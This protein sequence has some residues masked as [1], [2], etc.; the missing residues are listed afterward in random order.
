ML[1]TIWRKS[2]RPVCSGC[3]GTPLLYSKH[4]AASL[5]HEKWLWIRPEITMKCCIWIPRYVYRPFDALWPEAWNNFVY[6]FW[7]L[8]EI[9]TT[10]IEKGSQFTEMQYLNALQWSCKNKGITDSNTLTTYQ[11]KLTDILGTKPSLGITVW[12][13]S[14]WWCIY[15]Y[16]QQTYYI[17]TYCYLKHE[18]IFI[19]TNYYYENKPHFHFVKVKLM[20]LIQ[21]KF[22]IQ[23][24]KF[25]YFICILL[26]CVFVI[27]N[28]RQ[29]PQLLLFYRLILGIIK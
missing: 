20:T 29:S 6:K 1:Q 21:K 13:W 19:R 12:C 8:Q 28:S 23:S 15:A 16:S 10:I 3:A 22:A 5:R 2:I 4:W 26:V 25:L 27:I 7:S 17:T 24:K 9:L 14:I 11:Q 18:I